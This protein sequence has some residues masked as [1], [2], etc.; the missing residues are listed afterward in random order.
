LTSLTIPNKVTSIGE[1]AFYRCSGLISVHAHATTPPALVS[2]SFLNVP[3][4]SATLY[5]PVGSKAAYQ[6]ASIWS[7]FGTIIEEYP[8]RIEETTLE[9]AKIVQDEDGFAVTGYEASESIAIYSADGQ[10]LY[11]GTIEQLSSA[12][13]VK[14]TLYI[15]Q[16]PK[17]AIKV[18][19]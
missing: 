14:G 15:I 2:D 17:Q 12:N 11:S 19:Y 4:S 7:T 3:L 8:T 6:K 13:L 16:T 5:V 1:Y 9:E 10:L 18:V